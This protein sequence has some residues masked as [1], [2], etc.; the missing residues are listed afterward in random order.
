MIRCPRCDSAD[1]KQTS[2]GLDWLYECFTC[3]WWER[4]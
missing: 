2:A 1:V 3:G 4:R